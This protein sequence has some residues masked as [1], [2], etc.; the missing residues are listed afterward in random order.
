MNHGPGAIELVREHQ[1]DSGPCRVVA[2]GPGKQALEVPI[3]EG[4]GV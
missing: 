4:V 3:T 2:S 1:R